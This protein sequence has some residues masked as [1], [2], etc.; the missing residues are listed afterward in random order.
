MTVRERPTVQITVHCASCRRALE[1]EC[2]GLSGVT[3]YRTY[4][5]YI[6]PSCRKQNHALTP[7]AIVSV[8]IAAG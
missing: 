2:E 8:R 3:G 6:C 7:G 5:E 1:L 4:N